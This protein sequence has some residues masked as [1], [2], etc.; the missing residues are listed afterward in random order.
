MTVDDL[1]K[2]ASCQT[3]NE[4]FVVFCVACGAPIQRAAT[5]EATPKTLVEDQ[6]L[7]K[8]LMRRPRLVVVIG[9]WMLCFPSMILSAFMMVDI[10]ANY[11]TSS[12]IVFFWLTVGTFLLTVFILFRVTRNYLLLA[13]VSSGDYTDYADKKE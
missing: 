2:C 4:P 9:L 13:K 1:I 5:P 11:R 7:P 3:L 12:N 10:I 6:P 8:K